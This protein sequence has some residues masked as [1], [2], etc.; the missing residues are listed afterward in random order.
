MLRHLGLKQRSLP[1]TL[2][3]RPELF[4]AADLKL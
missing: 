4:A 1:L 2:L 3:L